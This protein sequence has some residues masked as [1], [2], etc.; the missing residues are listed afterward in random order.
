ME[1]GDSGDLFYFI[2][3][4]EVEIKIPDKDRD[5]KKKFESIRNEIELIEEEIS[6]IQK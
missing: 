6:S 3:K 1:F 5:R 2:L 4:G